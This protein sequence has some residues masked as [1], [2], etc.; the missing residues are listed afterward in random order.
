MVLDRQHVHAD[1]VAQQKLVDDF[2][3]QISGDAWVAIAVRQA[4]A[5]RL[6]GLQYLARHE[7]VRDFALPPRF[8]NYPFLFAA[9]ARLP[10]PPFGRRGRG[11]RRASAGRV[12][13][14]SAIT[15][16][17]PSPKPSPTMGEGASPCLPPA[18]GAPPSA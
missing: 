11:V 2:L 16:E 1:V 6:G 4:A 7:R 14:V 8:H 13:W 9:Y 18:A 3:E 10:S 17:T 15:P 5:H 12:R